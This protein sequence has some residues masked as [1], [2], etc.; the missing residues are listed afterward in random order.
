MPYK[1]PKDPRKLKGVYAWAAAHPEKVKEAKKKYAERNKEAVKQRIKDWMDK[2]PEKM[3]QIRMNWYLA[4]KHKAAAIV[5]KRQASKLKRTPKWLTDD[6]KWLMQQAYELASLRTKM[7]G[8]LW[9]VDHIIPLQGKKVSGLHVPW[10]LQVIP[11]KENYSKG[12]R[13]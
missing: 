8:F 1:D 9:T 11:A 6:D 2:N 12:N 3:K 10:N 7:F 13:V 4:N 5:R